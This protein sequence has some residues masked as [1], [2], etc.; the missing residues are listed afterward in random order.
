MKTIIIVGEKPRKVER[1]TLDMG[2][3]DQKE[4]GWCDHRRGKNWIATIAHHPGEPG[5]LHRHFWK[6]GSGSYRLMP[7][8]TQAGQYLEIAYD[9][10]GSRGKK[11]PDRLYF[12]VL[13]VTSDSIVLREANKPGR[14]PPNW[15][16]EAVEAEVDKPGRIEPE[17]KAQEPDLSVPDNLKSQG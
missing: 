2:Y 6:S 11:Y 4:I 10:I 8:D 9:Y 1:Y 13:Q 14:M 3:L 16:P 15:E 5:G 7:D 12:R 17:I